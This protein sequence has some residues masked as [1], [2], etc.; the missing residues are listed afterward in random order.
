MESPLC[1][2]GHIFRFCLS[3]VEIFLSFLRGSVFLAVVPDSVL[4]GALS[5]AP[6]GGSILL[7]LLYAA[8]SKEKRRS[9]LFIW[10]QGTLLGPFISAC[11]GLLLMS[12]NNLLQRDPRSPL[13]ALDGV[14]LASFATSLF[15]FL[16]GTTFY[17][18]ETCEN[19]SLGRS[20]AY[21]LNAL[22]SVSVRVLSLGVWLALFPWLTLGLLLPFNYILNLSVYRLTAPKGGSRE[23]ILYAFISL[24]HPSG[25]ARRQGKSSGDILNTLTGVKMAKGNLEAL[26][27]RHRLFAVLFHVLSLS[28]SVG[29]IVAYEILE[30]G[31]LMLLTSRE[32]LYSSLFLLLVASLAS[33]ALYHRSLVSAR[34]AARLWDAITPAHVGGSRGS[35]LPKAEIELTPVKKPGSGEAAVVLS[36]GAPGNNRCESGERDDCV[37]C[38]LL[39]LGTSFRSSM[40]GKDY[41][42]M[43]PVNCN[44]KNIIYLVTCNKCRKQY[45]GKTEQQFKQRHYGHRREIETK[46]SPLGKHFAD[47]CGYINWR[48]QI[49]DI[50]EVP[51]DLTRREGYWQQ[52]LQ[53]YAPQGLNSRR[54]KT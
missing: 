7:S 46:V 18:K 45:V 38:E 53:T 5:F 22:L 1:S 48:F 51:S 26:V 36:G 35:R 44:T 28:H 10:I 4:W 9:E 25:Y 20:F 12:A 21:L 41:R 11:P 8:F 24:L 33:S 2:K 13:S 31:S 42:L 34:K 47:E 49:I 3:L 40:T 15:V 29:L 52:E 32:V 16:L 39:I 50:C 27:G 23:C 54:E 30:H 17:D 37:T 6:S 19:G 14:Q 43:T